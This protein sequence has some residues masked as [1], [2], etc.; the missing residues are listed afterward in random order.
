MAEFKKKPDEGMSAKEV[1]TAALAALQKAGVETTGNEEVKPIV[2]EFVETWT[3]KRSEDVQNAARELQEEWEKREGTEFKSNKPSE[4]EGGVQQLKQQEITAMTPG[5]REE[6]IQD[7]IEE[8]HAKAQKRI[9]ERERRFGI[10]RHVPEKPDLSIVRAEAEETKLKEQFAQEM[11]MDMQSGKFRVAFIQAHKDY[12]NWLEQKKADS[13]EVLFAQFLG[14]GKPAQE[15]PVEAPAETVVAHGEIVPVEEGKEQ[16]RKEVAAFKAWAKDQGYELSA[17]RLKQFKELHPEPIVEVAGNEEMDFTLPE[18][19]QQPSE[20]QELTGTERRGEALESLK[21]MVKFEMDHNVKEFQAEYSREDLSAVATTLGFD[22]SYLAGQFRNS[23][24]IEGYVNSGL[25]EEADAGT[26]IAMDTKKPVEEGEEEMVFGEAEAFTPKELLETAFE[27][28]G[29]DYRG[30][31][32]QYKKIQERV[33]E[34]SDPGEIAAAN[35]EAAELTRNSL[36]QIRG[37]ES[38]IRKQFADREDV[39]AELNSRIGKIEGTV[40]STLARAAEYRAKIEDESVDMDFTTKDEIKVAA[41]EEEVTESESDMRAKKFAAQVRTIQKREAEEAAAKNAPEAVAP[42]EGTETP[43]AP[44]KVATVEVPEKKKE[45]VKAPTAEEVEIA[46]RK[47]YSPKDEERKDAI[48]VLEADAA[49][50]K[51]E[52]VATPEP[53]AEEVATEEHETAPETESDEAKRKREAREAILA[54]VKIDF[55]TPDLGLGTGSTADVKDLESQLGQQTA[56]DKASA[57]RGPAKG[58]GEGKAAEINQLKVAVGGATVKTGEVA[59]ERSV[60]R[61]TAPQKDPEEKG[62]VEVSVVQ[63]EKIVNGRLVELPRTF[64]N[65]EMFLGSY[66]AAANN[67]KEGKESGLSQDDPRMR[68]WAKEASLSREKVLALMPE[69]RNFKKM[70]DALEENNPD[71]KALKNARRTLETVNGLI[72]RWEGA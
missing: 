71:S 16:R 60:P 64:R 20:V 49:S 25:V 10:K 33:G 47:I 7:A 70:C 41:V 13:S 43:V 18:K 57:L 69:L 21:E 6:I 32:A 31:S 51:A 3:G 12:Q 22:N 67:F 42:E 52:P 24:E 53:K 36:E 68:G 4:E 26:K 59:E 66:E 38:E 27:K 34:T 54:N 29:V 65:M 61:I 8:G 30:F 58:K 62:G 17:E 63:L 45:N 2:N 40:K 46:G 44:K 72:T 56:T 5:R 55:E 14:E 11:G 1:Q 23:K 35:E 39:L 15:A 9:E 48:E 50:K 19:K 28:H 37:V